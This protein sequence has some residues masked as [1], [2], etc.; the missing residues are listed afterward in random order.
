MITTNARAES[1]VY[2]LLEAGKTLAL[3][4]SC[5]AGLVADR[6]ARVPGASGMLW[7]SFVC[8]TVGAKAAM[9]GIEP[10]LIEREGAVSEDVARAMAL[11][12]LR[13]S[14]C[15]FAASVTGLAGPDGDERGTPVGT[16][17]IGLAVREGGGVTTLEARRFL[18]EGGRQAVREQ[19]AEKVIEL[20]LE[21]YE[22]RH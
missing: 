12:A 14:G 4:E 3:A 18:F 16:V 11:G 2:K 1:L 7:G 21:G 19:A 20:L 9:L 22:V 6:I 8:Y 10:S 5:T 17:W 15:D 13:K